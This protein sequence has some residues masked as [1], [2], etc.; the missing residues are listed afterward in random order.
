MFR[1]NG[2]NLTVHHIYIYIWFVLIESTFLL[3]RGQSMTQKPLGDTFTNT[4][5]TALDLSNQL[6]KI[7]EIYVIHEEG[8]V[9]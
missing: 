8:N 6:H 5:L 1:V 2:G 3:T 9:R 7:H 4:D